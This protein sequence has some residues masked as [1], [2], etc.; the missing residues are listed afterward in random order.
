MAVGLAPPGE[1]TP[2]EGVRLASVA[3]GLGGA[4]GP[5]LVLIECA[6]GTRTAALIRQIKEKWPKL[7]LIGGGG[8]HG[9]EDLSQLANCGLS[10]V[11]VA[12]A[13]HDGR[14]SPEDLAD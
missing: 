12:S 3:A 13:L 5:D 6:E 10:R 8:V 1:L 4:D 14:L 2:V 11:L 9:P 7:E